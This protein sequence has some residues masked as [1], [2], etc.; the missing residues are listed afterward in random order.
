MA[1]GGRASP[2]PPPPPYLHLYLL[3]PI[4]LCLCIT[5]GHNY[6]Q[7]GL[8]YRTGSVMMPHGS[9]TCA[10]WSILLTHCNHLGTLV[11]EESLWFLKLLYWLLMLIDCS[12]TRKCT[13]SNLFK[14][15]A[16]AK[17]AGAWGHS[18]T[19][20]ALLFGEN[21]VHALFDVCGGCGHSADTIPHHDWL[22][23]VV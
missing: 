11:W 12:R 16:Q 14:T 22:N 5:I 7:I 15:S 23:N 10:I 3:S 8:V 2:P 13:I 6:L 21:S 1:C 17:P 4:S 19:F 9:I 20:I 18:A